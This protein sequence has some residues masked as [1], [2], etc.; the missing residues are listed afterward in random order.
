MYENINKNIA[1]Q[2]LNL[3]KD[4]KTPDD[5]EYPNEYLCPITYD[6]M[7]EPVK[8][9]DG[10]IYEKAAIVDWL[11]KHGTSPFTREVLTQELISQNELQ[12]HIQIFIKENNITKFNPSYNPEYQPPH[13]QPQYPQQYPPQPPYYPQQSS[14]PPQPPYYPQYPLQQPPQ[15]LQQPPQPIQPPQPPQP[16]YQRHYPQPPH[17]FP[18]LPSH[19]PPPYH[20]QQYHPN[21][22]YPPRL[23]QPQNT[24]QMIKCNLCQRQLLIN[25]RNMVN[26]CPCCKKTYVNI[27]CIKCNKKYIVDHNPLH[28]VKYR[29]VH[30]S[31]MNQLPYNSS[32]TIA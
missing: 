13:Q 16:L 25:M 2:N 31:T 23:P 19:F 17:V 4:A 27:Q 14:Y 3:S 32:C 28:N 9:S 15:P 7:L 30:C 21:V 22:P 24:N 29:C 1:T 18:P 5:F 10:Y 20:Y 6:L 11:K 26:K 12:N 8:A